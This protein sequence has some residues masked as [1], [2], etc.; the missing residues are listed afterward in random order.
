MKINGEIKKKE[1]K[2]N[3]KNRKKNFDIVDKK[4]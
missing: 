1:K 3:E 4:Y 2:R